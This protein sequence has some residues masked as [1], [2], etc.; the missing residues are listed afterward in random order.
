MASLVG[1][2]LARTICDE[3]KIKPVSV[4]FWSDSRIVL[5]WLNSESV[6]FKNFVGVCVAE[7]QS[8]WNPK[9]WRFVPTN[10]NPADDLS[11]GIS[12][13]DIDGC[14]KNGPQFLKG[15]KEEWPIKSVCQ[16]TED[17]PEKKETKI[18]APLSNQ[19][20]L[21][22]PLHYSSWQKLTRVTAYVL[23]FIHNIEFTFIPKK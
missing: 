10:L 11:R 22:D 5:H 7:I 12:L 20:P 18:M 15:P 6:S 17:D 2:Q 13:E 4:T 16:S 19:R 8:T 9:Y 14:W 1:S 3:F 23:H 21:I